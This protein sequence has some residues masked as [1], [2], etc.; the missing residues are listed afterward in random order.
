MKKIKLDIGCGSDK[1]KGC[2]GIDKFPIHGIVDVVADLEKGLP[3]FKDNTVDEIYCY[4]TLEH[5]DDVEFMMEEF[6][7]V[8]KNNGK[9]FIKV[10][11]F[12]S[13]IAHDIQH[14]RFFYFCSFDYLDDDT[15][16]GKKFSYRTKVKF[17]IKNRKIILWKSYVLIYT[18]FFSLIAKKFPNFYEQMFSYI[19][20]ASE[21][22]FELEAIK[23]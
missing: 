6:Y 17:K 9:V 18:Y 1:V 20:P 8:L 3:M 21:L 5:L 2:V 4:H 7:R 22:Y 15:W 19:S 11:H 23:R 14:K 13:R 10:P 12:S 16:V